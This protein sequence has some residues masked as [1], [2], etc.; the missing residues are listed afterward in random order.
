MPTPSTLA[1]LQ[2]QFLL[3]I[4]RQQSLSADLLSPKTTTDRMSIYIHNTQLTLIEL[5]RSRYPVTEQIVGAEFFQTLALHY[6]QQYRPT[7]GD[8]HVF[9][10]Q[11]TEFIAHYKPA[12][13]LIYLSDL[14]Q[15]EWRHHQAY[16]ADDATPITFEQLQLQLSTGNDMRLMLHPS[17][18]C[19]RVQYNVLDIWQAHQ[20][21]TIGAL[22]LHD[23]KH[24]LLIWRNPQHDILMQSVSSTL[25]DFL[26]HCSNS[27]LNALPI[28]TDEAFQ[29]EF[30]FCMTQGIFIE[31]NLMKKN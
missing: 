8:R 15:L 23:E 21:T 29:T 5:L 10:A 25:A 30:A 26:K 2:Q 3:A 28:T 18:N 27:F 31:E 14:A 4:Y 20:Q 17:V 7:S 1:T 6:L 9:G 16:F 12:A 22:T 13:S 19:L 11:L 24:E